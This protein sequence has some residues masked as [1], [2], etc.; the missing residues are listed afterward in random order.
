VLSTTLLCAPLAGK[1]AS[2]VL[3]LVRRPADV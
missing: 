2:E 1:R 3:L